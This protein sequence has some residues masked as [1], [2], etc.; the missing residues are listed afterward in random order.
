[1]PLLIKW[2]AFNK[3]NILAEKNTFG[4][5]EIGDGNGNIV[6]IGE[7]KLRDR[8]NSHFLGGSDP[9]GRSAKYRKESTGSKER[10]EERERAE[11]RAYKKTHN[12]KLPTY[13]ERLG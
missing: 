10:A 8:L 2:S 5:Y 1:M 13:N 9:I 6:Y 12:G 7:G 3:K 11:L 4:I